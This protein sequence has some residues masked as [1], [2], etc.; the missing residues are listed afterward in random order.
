MINFIFSLEMPSFRV[1]SFIEHQDTCSAVKHK[2]M[3]TGGGSDRVKSS[4][5]PPLLGTDRN[6]TGSPSQSSDTT[7]AVS[8][9]HSGMSDTAARSFA[10]RTEVVDEHSRRIQEDQDVTATP[11]TTTPPMPAWLTEHSRR[12]ELELLPSKHRVPIDYSKS[13]AT[14]SSSINVTYPEVSC[15]QSKSTPEPSREPSL[16]LSMGPYVA[17]VASS[18]VSPYLDT[19]PSFS[20]V[21]RVLLNHRQTSA[22]NVIVPR[23]DRSDVALSVPTTAL[24]QAGKK[25]MEGEPEKDCAV[26][27]SGFLMQSVRRLGPGSQGEINVGGL[28]HQPSTRKQQHQNATSRTKMV[29][30]YNPCAATGSTSSHHEDLAANVHESGMTC[31]D[32]ESE[33]AGL[34]SFSGVLLSLYCQ[35]VAERFW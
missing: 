11:S 5:A 7:Q 28:G 20:S 35:R 30:N 34:W 8:F 23:M 33:V 13:Q 14:R 1:E 18:S 31:S 24:T 12:N 19:K 27:L 29:A 22:G 16:H 3:Q 9:A 32:L 26:S 25:P 4:S 6:S 15:P 17:E 2:A 21:E 10:D